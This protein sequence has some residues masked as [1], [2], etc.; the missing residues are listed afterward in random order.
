MPS[1][2]KA[3][4]AVVSGLG[5]RV[6]RRRT[7]LGLSGLQLARQCGMDHSKLSHIE[8]ET[9]RGG[10]TAPTLV[11]LCKALDVSADWLLGLSSHQEP[12]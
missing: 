10:I 5:S 7:A 8:G 2:K 4:R 6:R 1:K 3:S 12:K 11:A 9:G